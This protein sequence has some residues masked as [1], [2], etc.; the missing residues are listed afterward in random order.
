ASSETL[1]QQSMRPEVFRT[2]NDYSIPAWMKPMPKTI[3][4]AGYFP[5]PPRYYPTNNFTIAAWIKPDTDIYALPRESVT[6]RVDQNG[7]S[8]VVPIPEVPAPDAL[9]GIAAGR[10][11]VCVMEGSTD[12]SPAVL[13]SRTPISGWTHLAVVYRDGKPALYLDGKLDREGLKSGRNVHWGVGALLPAG[14][15]AHYFDGDMTEPEVFSEPLSEE[16]IAALAAKGLPLPAGSPPIEMRFG[17]GGDVEAEV[18]Q[19]GNYSVD[20][21]NP[22]RV[23]VPNPV[24]V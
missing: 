6:G 23:S 21:R 16:Q 5:G 3:P 19:S 17:S 14:K 24:E 4:H 9:M 11:G 12:Q 2:T 13:V 15:L 22:M 10:N 18:W 8:F 7:K 1:F 20:G